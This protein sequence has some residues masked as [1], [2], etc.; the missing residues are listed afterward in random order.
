MQKVNIS[1]DDVTPWEQSGLD[2]IEQCERVVQHYPQVKFTLFVPT[3]YFRTIPP[4]NTK[5]PYFINEF[6]GFC[7]KLKTL[8]VHNYEI[9]YHGHFHGIINLSNNDEFVTGDETLMERKIYLM[10]RTAK[11]SGIDFKP[12]FRPPA[13]KINEYALDKLKDKGI[14]IMAGCKLFPYKEVTGIKNVWATCYPP[15]KPLELVD[16]TEI[17]YHACKWDQNYFSREKADE[18]IEFLKDKEVEY[19]FMEDM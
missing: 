14:K 8:S 19:C 18:L 5:A 1:I 2:V 9:G 13:W 16:Q 10:F 3:A 7:G 6:P 15:A 12:I 4:T 17:V 11:E